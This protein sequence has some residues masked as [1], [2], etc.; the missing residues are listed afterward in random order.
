MPISIFRGIAVAAA[1]CLAPTATFAQD[2]IGTINATLDGK[3]RTWFLTMQDSESQSFGLT[4][5]MANLQS[6]TLWGQATDQT[7]NSAEGSFLFTFEVMSVAGQMIPVNAS[8]MYMSDGWKSGWYADR[9]EN[10][11]SIAFSLTTL[12][13]D[14]AG[15]LVEGSFKAAA[16]FREPL[17]SGEIDPA[18]SMQID[19]NF[20]AMLPPSLLKT[21]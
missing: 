13:T 3:E 16:G 18:R 12:K 20:T 9:A 11:E 14:D 7:V 8:V 5:T 15:V 2:V 1:L 6:F 17:S 10:E 19:G 4:V 21:R